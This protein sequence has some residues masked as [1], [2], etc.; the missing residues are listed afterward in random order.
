[1]EKTMMKQQRWNNDKE[2]ELRRLYRF[3]TPS[4]ESAAWSTITNIWGPPSDWH[5]HG[6]HARRILQVL[7]DLTPKSLSLNGLKQR[8]AG[9]RRPSDLHRAIYIFLTKVKTE[10]HGEDEKSFR[11]L[12]DLFENAGESYAIIFDK[13]VMT[14]D[15]ISYINYYKRRNF[16]VVRARNPF[17][18]D[19][20]RGCLKET[21]WTFD[22]KPNQKRLDAFIMLVDRVATSAFSVKSIEDISFALLFE[23]MDDINRQFDRG[24]ITLMEKSFLVK[25]TI[26]FY[27]YC[28]R[29]GGRMLPYGPI[30][31]PDILFGKPIVAFFLDEYKS[32]DRTFTHLR[33]HGYSKWGSLVTIDIPNAILR[34]AYG[35][36]LSSGKEIRVGY[37]MCRSTLAESLGEHAHDVGTPAHPFTEETLLMQVNFYCRLFK[38]NHHRS[39]AITFVKQ[40]YLFLDEQS[41]GGFFKKARV[42]SYKLLTSR[43]FEKYCEEGFVF[44]RYSVYDREIEGDKIVF[45]VSGLNRY[46]RN[47]LSE[48]YLAFDFSC[49]NNAYYKRIAW[50][51]VTSTVGRLYRKSFYYMLR[52][53]LPFL[54][55]LKSSAGYPTPEIEAI[56]AWDMMFIAEYYRNKYACDLTYN[57]NVRE[58]RDFLKWANKAKVLNVDPTLVVKVLRGKRLEHIPTNTPV[59]MDDE[60]ALISSY[61]A[62]RSKHNPIYGQA[63]ILTH[64]SLLTPLRIGHSCTLRLDELYYCSLVD[65]YIAVST[66][67]GTRGD[68]TEIVLGGRASDFIKKAILIYEKNKKECREEQLN[69]YLFMYRF[70][71]GAYTVF[72]SRTYGRLLSEACDALGLPHYTSKNLRATYMTKAYVEAS[73]NGDANEFVLKLFSYHRRMGTT[74][75][76]YVNHSEALAALTDHLMRGNDW[77]KTLYPDEIEAL[78]NVIDMYKMLICASNDA[79]VKQRLCSELSRYENRLK[80]IK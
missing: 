55:N 49:V 76:H 28:F 51:A 64:L 11:T 52:E 3:A 48:D 70:Y 54:L 42:L 26:H 24:E 30:R 44:R 12:V 8:I 43:R 5:R 31:D 14:F 65:T 60:I 36:F 66:G 27:R 46:R 38:G 63:L 10:Y 78:Q 77:Q 58:V 37:G 79:N 25:D 16:Y 33:W 22:K 29:L 35:R 50:R 68:K 1:M 45:R 15:D 19:L 61:F 41:N 53:I 80:E 72:S 2:S 40:F 4:F 57:H 56:S 17:L 47:Y 62:N 32:L 23:L 75:E 9:F 74:L 21:Q 20:M 18:K 6:A 71:T 39:E 59:L 7:T 69:Q 73:E 67:K 13:N 34:N